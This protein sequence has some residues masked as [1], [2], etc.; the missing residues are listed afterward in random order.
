MSY[1]QLW[2][3][4]ECQCTRCPFTGHGT[5]TSEPEIPR[6]SILRREQD[7]RTSRLGAAA[8][9]CHPAFK[10]P[11]QTGAMYLYRSDQQFWPP[12]LSLP[13]WHMSCCSVGFWATFH[14]SAQGTW[15]LGVMTC[16]L[17][18]PAS[19][20]CILLP[21]GLQVTKHTCAAPHFLGCF[22]CFVMYVWISC[23]L[24][25]WQLPAGRTKD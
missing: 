7:T 14:N 13:G 3:G 20:R 8:L 15:F 2:V 16:R 21:Q 24:A 18:L 1:V 10:G 25:H 12:C 9:S 17:R 5:S 4:G 6:Q 23:K 19:A 22:G 11:H